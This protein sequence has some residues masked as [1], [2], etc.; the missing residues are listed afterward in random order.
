M[1]Y[2][3]RHY[4]KQFFLLPVEGI[5][6]NITINCRWNNWQGILLNPESDFKPTK[7]IKLS[8]WFFSY[9]IIP[10]THLR[11]VFWAVLD[12]FFS[13]LI[14][15]KLCG[16]C[17]R[18]SFEIFPALFK[19]LQDCLNSQVCLLLLQW[20]SIRALSCHTIYHFEDT[21]IVCDIHIR[22]LPLSKTFHHF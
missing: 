4:I 16:S 9:L 17:L 19:P 2:L 21:I 13:S 14:F 20:P 22:F 6:L 11:R 12:A 5:F 15:N 7:M 18:N 10:A 3:Q 8:P 1:F